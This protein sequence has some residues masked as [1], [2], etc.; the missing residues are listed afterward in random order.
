MSSKKANRTSA[1]TA[2]RLSEPH[3]RIRHRIIGEVLPIDSKL[4]GCDVIKGRI[5]DIVAGGR[6]RDRA[7]VV[8]HKTNRPV[9]FEIVVLLAKP[10]SLGS[11][12][13]AAR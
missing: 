6:I 9:R 8:W 3:T 10:C 1:A 5:G 13:A 2:V 7:V 11:S 12:V 4:R